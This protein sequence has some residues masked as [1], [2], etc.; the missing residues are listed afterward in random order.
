MGTIAVKRCHSLL[1]ALGLSLFG[2]QVR[3]VPFGIPDARGMAMGGA[4]VSL[5]NSRTAV[6]YNPALLARHDAEEDISGENSLTAPIAS[7]VASDQ[8]FNYVD[9]E[10]QDFHNQLRSAINTYNATL[11]TTAAQNVA[12]VSQN[13]N[14]A[15]DDLAN[16]NGV[17]DVHGGLAIGIPSLAK[18]G[19]FFI[20]SR[21]V[22]IG[23]IDLTE[24]DQALLDAYVDGMTYVASGGAQGSEQPQLFDSNG[25]LLDLTDT[26]DS[27]VSGKAI[28]STEVGVALATTARWREIDIQLGV[29]PKIQAIA[30][31][32]YRHTVHD[33]G[34]TASRSDVTQTRLNVDLGATA[35]HAEH[36]LVG[37]S[38]KN[39]IPRDLQ[40]AL[41]EEIQLRPS[42]RAGVAY[43]TARYRIGADLDLLPNQA[44]DIEDDNQF[45]GVG[46]EFTANSWL[47]LRGG[48]QVDL[49]NAST[50]NLLSVG[51]GVEL[52]HGFFDLAIGKG[53]SS[54]M[55]ALQFGWLF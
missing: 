20:M 42:V 45:L 35:T 39:L 36:W 18:G 1:F 47:S 41:G 44:L 43:S 5:A 17:A 21:A 38:I 55:A 48:F 13:L 15:L 37:M 24:H 11:S 32:D 51:L 4:T 22:G 10:D 33:S 30:T 27:T 40:T 54:R 19:S 34:A 14:N 46:S 9:Y 23:V 53:S 25:Q 31:Y 28:I 6:F 8:L 26:L 16:Q 7:G 52:K 49:R 2:P 50:H 12:D 3:A 29:A